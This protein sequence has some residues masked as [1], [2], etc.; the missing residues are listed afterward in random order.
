MQAQLMGKRGKSRAK[1]QISGKGSGG[2]QLGIRSTIKKKHHEKSTSAMAIDGAVAEFGRALQPHE[3]GERNLVTE[4]RA[5]EIRLISLGK[6]KKKHV[7]EKRQMKKNIE[8]IDR[9]KRKQFKRKG[10]RGKDG[11]FTKDME[12]E[13]GRKGLIKERQEMKA[14]LELRHKQEIELKE[15]LNSEANGDGQDAS[16]SAPAMSDFEKT[17]LA[18]FGQPTSANGISL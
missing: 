10:T 12:T 9:V 8:E 11:L 2:L 1:L 3:S 6:L 14:D 17:M 7:M 15:R 4:E 13:A 18:M 16:C 5:A